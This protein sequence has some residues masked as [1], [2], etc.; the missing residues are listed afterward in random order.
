MKDDYER[1]EVTSR[2][3]WRAWLAANHGQA[4]PIWLVTYKQAAGDRYLPYGAIVEEALCF[5]WIDSLPRKLDDLRTMLLLS[6]RKPGSGWSAANRE[7]AERLIADGQ[8]AA[9]GLAIVVAARADGSWDR[10]R[11]PETGDPPADLAAALAAAGADK[12]FTALS[13]ATRKRCLEFLGSARR[14]ETRAARIA[15][16]VAGAQAGVDPL[17]WRPKTQATDAIR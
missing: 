16:I 10:L 14:A 11:A 15:K 8:M 9:A 4:T 1:V 13:L 7:R 17:A 6:P 5:G 12:G 3:D 2:A